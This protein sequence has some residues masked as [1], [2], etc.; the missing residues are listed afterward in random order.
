MRACIVVGTRSFPERHNAEAISRA[1]MG[2]RLDFGLPPLV[3]ARQRLTDAEMRADLEQAFA[4]ENPM[5]RLPLTTDCAANM[6]CAAEKEE[7]F[8]WHPCICH[9]LNTA[10]KYGLDT[11]EFRKFSGPLQ[12]L[13]AHLRRSPSGWMHFRREQKKVLREGG[14]EDLSSGDDEDYSAVESEDDVAELPDDPD[15]GLEVPRLDTARA[16]PKRILRLGSWCPTRWN[17]MYFLMKRAVLLERSI[18]AYTAH[19]NKPTIIIPSNGWF[20]FKQ[21]LPAMDSIRELS[22][23]CEGDDYITI[24][25][26]LYNVLKLLYDRLWYSEIEEHEKP[27]LHEFVE[28]FKGKLCEDLDNVNIIYCW[29]LAAVMDG[30]RSSL[31]W[32]RR[33]WDNPWD[34]P[35]L[36][37]EYRTLSAFKAM[38]KDEVL[39]LVS[40][41]LVCRLHFCQ[42]MQSH[43]QD[44]GKYQLGTTKIPLCMQVGLHWHHLAGPVAFI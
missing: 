4:A 13:A 6:I 17:S 19:A 43:A 8:D 33:I 3:P 23:R 40:C 9:L 31:H 2:V 22:E 24:S 16:R 1:I 42:D 15:G 32:M 34:W 44:I 14:L 5:D 12:A 10:V 21:V 28:L 35:K 25:D 38:L 39:Q 36:T 27:A 26:V 29:A 37:A 11:A 20:A 41:I 18:R 30:R 7:I